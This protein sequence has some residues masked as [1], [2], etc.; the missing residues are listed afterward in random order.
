MNQDLE[1]TY[2]SETL[3]QQVMG[4][5]WL[6]IPLRCT[7]DSFGL[8]EETMA[9]QLFVTDIK[10]QKGFIYF[11]KTNEDGFLTVNEAPMWPGR[12]KKKENIENGNQ[13]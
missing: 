12:K 13:A 5:E 2:K 4:S 7:Q 11:C 3:L 10:S 8:M 1:L 6:T 9:R